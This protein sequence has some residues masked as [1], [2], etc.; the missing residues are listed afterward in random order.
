VEDHTINAI[1]LLPFYV[2]PYKDFY[3]AINPLIT[4]GF[5]YQRYDFSSLSSRAI[6]KQGSILC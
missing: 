1:G 6:V 4:A 3:Y 5:Y 2:D